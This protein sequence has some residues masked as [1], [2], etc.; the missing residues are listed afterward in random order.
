MN[1]Q[2]FLLILMTMLLTLTLFPTT[3][4]A[5]TYRV[6]E[7]NGSWSQYDS[8]LASGY[9]QSDLYQATENRG[10][11]T[12]F[13]ELGTSECDEGWCRLGT[14]GGTQHA[15]TSISQFIEGTNSL[16]I[17]QGNGAPA[18]TS[19]IFFQQTAQA[20][21]SDINFAYRYSTFEGD[22][23]S[24]GYVDDANRFIAVGG[25]TKA[26]TDW[27][28]QDYEIPS[29][30]YR[31]AFQAVSGSANTI[32]IYIDDI[33]VTRNNT[34]TF[35]Y[36]TEPTD[37]T[38]ISSCSNIE[39]HLPSNQLGELYWAVDYI[40]GA[41]CSAVI[42]GTPITMTEGLGGMYYA[43]VD[44][45][46]TSG[47]SIDVD[48]TASCS[49]VPA[50]TKNFSVSPKL[51]RYNNVEGGD[52]E[53]VSTLSDKT[54]ECDDYFCQVFSSLTN[55]T[56][57]TFE[58]RQQDSTS[59]IKSLKFSYN[60]TSS[61]G[62]QYVTFFPILS[63]TYDGG[64]TIYF[65]YKEIGNYTTSYPLHYGYVN[66]NNTFTSKGTLD[67]A[68]TDWTNE[69][70]VIPSG[71]YRLAFQEA[72]NG[73]ENNI[74]YIDNI[75]SSLSKRTST[76]V[77]SDSAIND[78]AL[79][80]DT[81]YFYGTYNDEL[82]NPITD[83]TCTVTSGL[84]EVSLTYNASTERY[85][86]SYL[87]ISN[88]TFS[89][90]TT[91][92]STN[93]NTQTSTPFN[94][95]I[96][97]SLTL[98]LQ[99]TVISGLGSIT[100]SDTNN[101][102]T[103]NDISSSDLIFKVKT[104]DSAYALVTN[105]VN[106]DKSSK[107]YFVYTSLDG[108]DWT[109]SDTITFGAT[110]STP[111]QKIW[112]D[113]NESYNYSFN[114]D[115]TQSVWQYYKLVYQAPAYYSEVINSSMYWFNQNPPSNFVDSSGKNFDVFA[116]SNYTNI[117]SYTALPFQNLVS[118]DLTV[119]YQLQ[120]T[121][122]GTSAGTLAVGSRADG[123]DSTSN[124]SVTTT[125]TRFSIPIVPSVRDS[126]LL[127]KS[128]SATSNTYY[129]TDYTIVPRS[130]FFNQLEIVNPDRTQLQ[131]ILRNGTSTQYVKEGDS[132]IL[133][134]SMYDTTG[135]LSKIEIQTYLGGT[136][137]KTQFIDISSSAGN[138]INFDEAIEG[139]IDLNGIGGE[140]TTT[141]S[142]RTIT[143]K[144][145]L[146]NTDDESVSEQY[147]TV[148]LLQFP[149]FPNDFR[150]TSEIIN[151]KLGTNPKARLNIQTR[152]PTNFLGVEFAF[153]DSAHSIAT[154]NYKETLYAS[155]LSCTSLLSC[156]KEIVF[157]KYVWDSEGDF[158]VQITALIT[159]ENK[160]YTDSY[161]N[162][163][164]HVVVTTSG[165]LLMQMIQ[166]NERH[167]NATPHTPY[168]STER[169]PLMLGVTDDMG[170]NLQDTITP[171]F[172]LMV[173]DVNYTTQ[174][175]PDAFNYD[176]ASGTN[177]WLWNQ[178][179][180]D[181]AGNL[182]PDLN[183]VKFR[184]L[185]ADK[186]QSQ[187]TDN[188]FAFANR[189]TLYPVDLLGDSATYLAEEYD[190]LGGMIGKGIFDWKLKDNSGG[191]IAQYVNIYGTVAG[192]IA[193]NGC[194]EYPPNIVGW[195]DGNE[196]LITIDDSF[197]LSLHA[198]NRQALYCGQTYN[199]NTIT[200]QLGDDFSCVL[201]I[202]EDL[203]QIDQVRVQIGN[204]NSD[205]SVVN[206]N[207]QYLDFTITGNDIIFNDMGVILAN[208]YQKGYYGASPTG[209]PT[210]QQ[211]VLSLWH[212]IMTPQLSNDQIA[213]QFHFTEVI[214]GDGNY[215]FE[216]DWNSSIY[217]KAIVFKIN[218]FNVLNVYDYLTLE[219]RAN[220]DAKNFLS[221]ARANNINVYPKNLNIE[222][223]SNNTETPFRIIESS[224]PII[225]NKNPTNM[226]KTPIYTSDG[227]IIL[228]NVDEILPF[229][230]ISTMS[231]ANSSKNSRLIANLQFRQIIKAHPVNTGGIIGGFNL[232][233]IA[234][235]IGYFFF[236]EDDEGNALGAFNAP[237][238][239]FV[240]NIIVIIV[241][242]FLIIIFALVFKSIA[243]AFKSS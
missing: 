20:G 238:T 188:Q 172:T 34:G 243:P 141:D 176:E 43:L 175:Y 215:N 73:A 21:D 13:G 149:Y 179:L 146:Y 214:G 182:L 123:S 162:A 151:T 221:Y 178:Y 44:V 104:T 190:W 7:D 205:Y 201:L 209:S 87:F 55:V 135:D 134:T 41:T 184:G 147:K 152:I 83:A 91:C 148:S 42:N 40:S 32:D 166:Y 158:T 118:G 198:D 224:S 31:L 35:S 90:S 185:I 23:F 223:Y 112:N 92:T 199:N 228:T 70:F 216:S 98:S 84:S 88:G 9:Y 232:P 170:K 74:W 25:L 219:E 11:E 204:D 5:L 208:W 161:T 231:S 111:V 96:G 127:I 8:G 181:D 64:A 45:A 145:I 203:E 66:D 106:S 67:F 4:G 220:F 131:S 235:G 69:S 17:Y 153:Y 46:V 2:F 68:D 72:S 117:Q 192:S 237:S 211:I 242:I 119:G 212:D 210:V 39:D 116:D 227:N 197:D 202:H 109:F 36:F 124:I 206:D 129:I 191:W 94:L 133:K 128:T 183:V 22:S 239:W 114:S 138:Y 137:V 110:T 26:D 207:K 126:V 38:S 108:D 102:I 63:S 93:Y 130:Y 140:L 143:Y 142:L 167:Q 15:L 180:Y 195:G 50:I 222:L 62:L 78:S 226:T 230:V 3:V 79:R 19:S 99:T 122:Y 229:H 27:H 144:A 100:K 156:T 173:D 85:E 218:N 80:G 113:S 54:D 53:Y 71:N 169:V 75:I 236:G 217:N 174:F 132:V 12:S 81:V 47:A 121:A 82:D 101:Q 24:Y 51:Y 58:T 177:I 28:Y 196:S 30:N 160:N 10:F 155:D 76:L 233:A 37:C 89:T 189:C 33:T 165:Y 97:D 163:K 86:G 200:D 225:I 65:D 48:L 115:L 241:I 57:S 107:Q 139:V 95:V 77:V 171:Y 18:S 125:P 1:K 61:S 193:Q 164:K 56:S 16:Y 234:E 60:R 150:M 49:R 59:G 103:L 136:L 194:V 159:T 14:D 187:S 240:N 29:G 186:R 213:D 120:F 154:P 168:N 52:F 6:D 105:W 157:D